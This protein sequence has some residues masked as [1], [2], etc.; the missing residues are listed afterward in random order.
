MM[1]YWYKKYGYTVAYC[2]YMDGAWTLEGGKLQA[3][4]LTAASQPTIQYW[5]TW[6]LPRPHFLSYQ[7]SKRDPQCF[8]FLWAGKI[9]YACKHKKM[10]KLGKA[11]KLGL[12]LSHYQPL[13][14]VWRVLAWICTPFALFETNHLSNPTPQFGLPRF[15]TPSH[16]DLIKGPHML[17]IQLT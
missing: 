15:V 16:G 3:I 8:S 6:H 7:N 1:M 12:V 4:S 9:L 17:N 13:T 2:P 11:K 14:W 5:S 10:Q